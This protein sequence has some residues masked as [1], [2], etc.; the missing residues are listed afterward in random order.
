MQGRGWYCDDPLLSPSDSTETADVRRQR[1]NL[2]CEANDEACERSGLS[3][4]E[5]KQNRVGPASVRR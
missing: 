2:A 4:E 5:A 1:K 3:V